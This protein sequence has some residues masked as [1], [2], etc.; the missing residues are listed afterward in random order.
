M[1]NY[2]TSPTTALTD[3]FGFGADLS[4]VTLAEIEDAFVTAGY[5][6]ERAEQLAAEN[7]G[8]VLPKKLRIR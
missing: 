5:S 1:T 3:A 8:R 6:L 4:R 7:D 2:L